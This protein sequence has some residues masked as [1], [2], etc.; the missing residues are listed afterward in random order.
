MAV[1]RYEDASGN[2]ANVIDDNASLANGSR[3]AG[4]LDNSTDRN[5]WAVPKLTVQYDAGPPIAGDDIAELFVIPGDGAASEEFAEGG[6]AGLGTDDDPQRAFYVGTFI[7][8]NPSTTVDEVL[9]LPPLNL[10]PAG[11]RFVVKNVSGQAFDA[12]WQLDVLPYK[13]ESN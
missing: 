5:F 13:T 6:D 9:M 8:V 7:S 2:L 10:Y 11:N 1:F 3:A 4:D 12:T